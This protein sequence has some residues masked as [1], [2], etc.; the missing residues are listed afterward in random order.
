MLSIYAFEKISNSIPV[1][2]FHYLFLILYAHHMQLQSGILLQLYRHDLNEL[3]T[4]GEGSAYY[5]FSYYL[6]IIYYQN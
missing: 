2:Y 6:I 4:I 1:L 3:E 5:S